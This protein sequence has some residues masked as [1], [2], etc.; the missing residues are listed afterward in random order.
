V[1]SHHRHRRRGSQGARTLRAL[2]L[3][4]GRL[5]VDFVLF[6]LAPQVIFY[7]TLVARHL[8]RVFDHQPEARPPILERA[9][10]REKHSIS[11]SALQTT[12]IEE[13]FNL[14]D[15]DGGGSIDRSELELALV[16]HAYTALVLVWAES[17]CS[18]PLD[19]D[20]SN[21]GKRGGGGFD[22]DG[23]GGRWGGRG[24]PPV[25]SGAGAGETLR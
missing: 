9:V 13:I 18:V 19:G 17:A 10:A 16:R 20:L 7:W 1:Q 25:R 2:G 3:V 23:G 12:Q 4:S 5:G 24:H 11:L 8:C 22:L 15:T 21:E 14:F 6:S